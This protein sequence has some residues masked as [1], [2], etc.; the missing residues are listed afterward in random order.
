MPK[1]KAT[2]WSYGH[3]D[4]ADPSAFDIKA[5]KASSTVLEYA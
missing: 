4:Y 2:V 3:L 1:Y 5:P